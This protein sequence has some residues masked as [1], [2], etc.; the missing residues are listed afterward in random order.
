MFNLVQDV[1]THKNRGIITPSPGALKR[2]AWHTTRQIQLHE[3]R[4]SL[5]TEGGFHAKTSI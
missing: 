2:D 5:K 3:A 4:I 1:S